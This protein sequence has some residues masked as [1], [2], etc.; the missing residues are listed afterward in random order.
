MHANVTICFAC[1][2]Y[3]HIGLATCADEA[4]RLVAERRLGVASVN[5]V[6]LQAA[7]LERD[8]LVVG[9]HAGT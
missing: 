4:V 9:R 7:S 5:A 2:S 6:M 1:P 3:V 8:V